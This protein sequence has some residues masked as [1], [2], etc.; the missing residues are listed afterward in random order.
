MAVL[1]DVQSDARISADTRTD[2]GETLLPEEWVSRVSEGFYDTD[3]EDA[4]DAENRYEDWRL[5]SMRVT[6]CSP[7]GITPDQQMDEL[8]WPAVRLV[9]QPVLEDFQLL[10]G[11]YTDFYAD[12]RAIHAIY[13]VHP[14]YSDGSRGPA[15]VRDKVSQWLAQGGSPN[16]IPHDVL[17]DFEQARNSSILWLMNRLHDLRHTRLEAGSWDAIDI[18]PEILA[19][20][21]IADEFTER[22]V[23]FLGDFA[24]N[25]DLNE[26]TAFSL[27][28]GRNPAGSDIWVFI[29]F[30]GNNGDPQ[31]KALEVIGRES[32]EVLITIG[33]AQTIAVGLEDPAVEDALAEG[34]AELAESLIISNEDID[35]LGEDMA[36]P[37]EFLVPNTSCASCHRLNDLLF[38]FHSLSGF[39]NNPITV[40]PR[41]D[42]DVARDL[43]WARSRGL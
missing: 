39:E 30:D 29:G 13:P 32:G 11:T 5:V 28:E 34:S 1:L 33:T 8:C 24:S 17:S 42:K 41:V 6:P 43:S 22:M 20:G 35:I 23:A 9:W 2:A 12:D 38:D 18:R 27:P 4:L 31:L 40:S 37:Y 26:M 10:W 21:E 19:D 15:S 14:R 7:I 36:D 25:Q 3:V 16:D